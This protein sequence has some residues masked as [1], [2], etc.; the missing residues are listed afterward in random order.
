MPTSTPTNDDPYCRGLVHHINVLL[1]SQE[2]PD[3]ARCVDGVVYLFLRTLS[4]VATTL[5]V[6]LVLQGK[7]L[8]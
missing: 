3:D 7:S 8:I 6:N 1:G 2:V 4:G 5:S